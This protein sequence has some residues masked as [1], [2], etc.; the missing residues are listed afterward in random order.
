M[1]E[2]DWC[3]CFYVS[4][5][6]ID[7]FNKIHFICSSTWLWNLLFAFLSSS[8]GLFPLLHKFQLTDLSTGILSF[9]LV[10][11]IIARL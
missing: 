3:I 7:G 9:Y 5:L 11:S 10:G 4:L 6:S 1:C 8:F 2:V